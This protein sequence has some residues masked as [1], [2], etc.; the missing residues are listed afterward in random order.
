MHRF[1][2]SDVFVPCLLRLSTG[3]LILGRIWLIGVIKKN[4]FGTKDIGLE[5]RDN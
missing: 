1:L 2:G 3:Q 5:V 4:L